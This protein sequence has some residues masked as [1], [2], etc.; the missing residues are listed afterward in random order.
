MDWVRAEIPARGH[1]GVE[2]EGPQSS[3]GSEKAPSQTNVVQLDDWIGPR[4]DL[5]PF[6]HRQPQNS[7]LNAEGSSS[8]QEL[9]TVETPPSADDFWGERAAAIH[10]AVQAPAE[11][12]P[13]PVPD[14]RSTQT[15]PNVAL[16]RTRRNRSRGAAARLAAGAA[17]LAAAA[18]AGIVLAGNLFSNGPSPALGPGGPKM[19]LASVLSN[20]VSRVLT[21]D[22][23][24]IASS[25]SHLAARR[26]ARAHLNKSH[27]RTSAEPAHHTRPAPK[28]ATVT[29]HSSATAYS[30]RVAP[31]TT[32]PITT[33]NTNSQPT[34]SSR[35]GSTSSAT[36]PTAAPVSPTGESGALGPIA[37]PNG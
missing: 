34:T 5:V 29:S 19:P 13:S 11:N 15:W 10:D 6:G 36:S 14:G 12:R 20:G 17:F 21:L 22:L 26:G 18:V 7:A 27:P 31:A 2:S 28:R 4:D 1:Q 33:T 9:P 37:S 24:R 8:T 30:A 16:R 35:P 25:S 32:P 23:P 3:E